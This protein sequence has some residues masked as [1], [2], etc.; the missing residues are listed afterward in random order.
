MRTIEVVDVI[1]QYLMIFGLL[2]GDIQ[3]RSFL[4]L[5]VRWTVNQVHFNGSL[6]YIF[7]VSAL[8][9]ERN[10]NNIIPIKPEKVSVS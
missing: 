10:K 5:Y 7:L 6:L 9:E 2:L 3:K 4:P 1:T 8:S